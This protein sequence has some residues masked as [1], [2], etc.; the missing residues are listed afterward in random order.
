MSEWPKVPT[1]VNPPEYEKVPDFHAAFSVTLGELIESG[2]LN[3]LEES[4]DWSAW[5]YDDETFKRLTDA[6]NERFFDQEICITPPGI[7]KRKLLYKIRYELCP[8]YNRL[9]AAEKAKYDLA[10]KESTKVDDYGKDR[11]IDSSFPETLLSANSDYA[12]AGSDSEYEHINEKTVSDNF[13]LKDYLELS[14]LFATYQSI[15]KRFL[16]DLQTMFA[17]IW[18]VSINGL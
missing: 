1:V 2:W 17:S 18:S 16:D 14:D 11:R 6:F 8:K 5:A 7:W 10:S 9:Y 4:W 3:W 12:S 15:D 13:K